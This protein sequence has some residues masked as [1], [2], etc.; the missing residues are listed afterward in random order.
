MDEKKENELSSTDAIC[1]VVTAFSL[2]FIIIGVFIYYDTKEP[3][4]TLYNSDYS[5]VSDGEWFR[6]KD[7]EGNL[8]P[9]VYSSTKSW[10]E[11]LRADADLRMALRETVGVYVDQEKAKGLSIKEIEKSKQ[12]KDFMKADKDLT[13]SFREKDKIRKE[14][15]PEIKR[16]WQA[17]NPLQ[18]KTLIAA[19]VGAN[20]WI[21]TNSK[22]KYGKFDKVCCPKE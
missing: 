17:E 8:V 13:K 20:F 2:I 4:Y 11:N 1:R 12:Y 15:L 22:I 14:Q 18:Y 16:K 19:V 6:I 21:E 10:R 9:K 5:I 3:E 7:P